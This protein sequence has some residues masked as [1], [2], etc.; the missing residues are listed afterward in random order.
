ML[1]ARYLMK[2]T[3]HS[4]IFELK[5]VSLKELLFSFILK[6]KI[7]LVNFQIFLIKLKIELL[8]LPLLN[9]ELE[10]VG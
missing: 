2:V 7:D 10:Y 1:K 8:N 6:L 5:Q 4:K 9:L 3:G